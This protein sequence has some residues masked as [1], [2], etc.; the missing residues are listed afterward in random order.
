[1]PSTY[2]SPYASS[3]NAAIKRGASY[4]TAVQN[5]ADRKNKNSAAV[6][7]SLFKAGHCFRQKFNGKWIYFPC[8]VKKANATTRSVT[9][10]NSWQWFCEWCLTSGLA[11]PAQF[12]NHTGSQ[13]EFMTWCRKFFGRQFA[14]TTKTTRRKTARRKTTRSKS[15]RTKS[16]P[17][18]SRRRSAVK[19]YK[20]PAKRRS[21]TSS[22][23][24]RAA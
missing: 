2:T 17:S 6:W 18:K 4:T 19:S 7:E 16:A 9:Q 13:K 8:N 1:M 5:I 12:N 23:Y 21:S 20:F 10:Y 3:F 22:R 14:A 15:V 11:T 24:R